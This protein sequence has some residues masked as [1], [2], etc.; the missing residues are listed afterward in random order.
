M[1]LRIVRNSFINQ[2]KAMAV[3]IVAVAV[4]TAIASSLISLSLDIKSKVSKELR[5][6][7]A[8]IIV[9]PRA[10]GIAELAGQKRYLRASDLIKI[11]TIFW[12]HNILGF[13]PFLFVDDPQSRSPVIG[14]WYKKAVK[15]PGESAPF[16]TGAA[17]VMPWWQI[18]GRWPEGDN[19][20]LVGSEL[21]SKLN[22]KQGDRVRLFDKDFTVSGILATGAK[23]D[24]AFV[25]PLEV[26]QRISGLE[27]KISSVYVSALTTPMDDFAYKDPEKMSRREYEKWYC[28]GYVTSIAKQIEEVMKGS[29]ARP[30]WPVAETEGKVLKRLGL[31]IYLLSAVSV[32]SA[33]LGVSTTMVMSL[34]RRTRQIALMKAIGADR[35]RTILIF[36][37]EALIVGCVGGVLGYLLSLFISHYIGI[38]VFGTPLRQRAILFPMSLGASVL[39]AVLGS[40]LPIRK[41]LTIRP[42]LILKGE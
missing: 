4:G 24:E 40:Y 14:T 25:L 21:S 31:L 36:L 15:V 28:T 11:K 2:K 29:R 7:G 34:L 32:L 20:V 35:L 22:L 39:I 17:E 38:E 23:E 6:F 5:A 16:I 18:K 27:N 19:E 10:Q 13:V 26:L 12:R 30:I 37:T 3:M 8:N 9:E 42:A 33:S 41:A 1:L